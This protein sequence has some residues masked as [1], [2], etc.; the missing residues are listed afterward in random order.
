MEKREAAMQKVADKK[1]A[2]LLEHQKSQFIVTKGERAAEMKKIM[3]GTDQTFQEKTKMVDNMAAG[4]QEV[5]LAVQRQQRVAQQALDDAAGGEAAMAGA[6]RS[7]RS[8]SR[9]APRR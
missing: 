7:G 1:Y 9:S 3:E 5:I 2:G 4:L 6:A 8:C